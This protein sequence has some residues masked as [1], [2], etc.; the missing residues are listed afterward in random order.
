MSADWTV[1]A[2]TLGHPAPVA[3]IT[4][5]RSTSSRMGVSLCA[6]DSSVSVTIDQTL[7]VLCV[8]NSKTFPERSRRGNLCTRRVHL[9]QSRGVSLVCYSLPLLTSTLVYSVCTSMLLYQLPPVHYVHCHIHLRSCVPTV[10][11]VWI[12]EKVTVC[13]FPCRRLTISSNRLF[14]I[15]N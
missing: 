5:A 14:A 10:C 11:T 12:M 1:S 4:N 2:A 6:V 13:Q 8:F 3:S 15:S 7:I 9:R